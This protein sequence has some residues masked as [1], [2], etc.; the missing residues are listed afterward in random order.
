MIAAVVF[1]WLNFIAQLAG[2][3]LV[4]SLMATLS[5]YG[6]GYNDDDDDYNDDYN[7]D[8]DDDDLYGYDDDTSAVMSV[9]APLMAVVVLNFLLVVIPAI[10]ASVVTAQFNKQTRSQDDGVPFGRAKVHGIV[11]IVVAALQIVLGAAVVGLAAT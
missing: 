7:D 10:Y 4:A 2:I 11:L 1:L 9:F 6:Y 8:D 3:G 5:A